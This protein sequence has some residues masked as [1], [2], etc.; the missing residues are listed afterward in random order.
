[1]GSHVTSEKESVSHSVMS[2]S[3]PSEPLRKPKREI[4]WEEKKIKP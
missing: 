3:L 2:D 4:N 1:M